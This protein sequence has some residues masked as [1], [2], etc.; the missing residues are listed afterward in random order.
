MENYALPTIGEVYSEYLAWEKYKEK[1][2]KLLRD[3]RALKE[4]DR[5]ATLV[6]ELFNLHV[7]PS[8]PNRKFDADCVKGRFVED[9]ETSENEWEYNSDGVRIFYSDAVWIGSM[10]LS[11]VKKV[12]VDDKLVYSNLKK[13]APGARV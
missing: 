6:E 3:A 5:C 12:W 4:K 13:D 9:F 7:K 1:L 8:S 2:E 10:G 11:T